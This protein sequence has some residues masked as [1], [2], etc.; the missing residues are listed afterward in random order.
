[1]ENISNFSNQMGMQ[2]VNFGVKREKI[3]WN[4]QEF[5]N[6]FFGK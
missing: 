6:L 5:Q 1:M 3:G 4:L 2:K